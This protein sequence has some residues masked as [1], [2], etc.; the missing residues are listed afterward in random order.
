[1]QDAARRLPTPR[2]PATQLDYTG[3]FFE[4]KCV[5]RRDSELNGDCADAG[6]H[7][8]TPEELQT[9]IFWAYDGAYRIGLPNRLYNDN[10][11]AIVVAAETRTGAPLAPSRRLRLYTAANV[12]MADAAIA[13]WR[14][15]YF[16]TFWR[17][18]VGTPIDFWCMINCTC[19]CA[20]LELQVC[21]ACAVHLQSCVPASARGRTCACV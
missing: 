18:T 5:G 19:T 1:M 3:N 6:R 16:F 10:L 11:D 21:Q 2:P 14:D 15:K 9:G 12:A 20:A 7:R 17:P 8:R 4:V 13:A